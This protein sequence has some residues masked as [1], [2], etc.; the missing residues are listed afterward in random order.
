MPSPR[1][2]TITT[3]LLAGLLGLA[4]C[5]SG[6]SNETASSDSGAAPATSAATSPAT[7]TSSMPPSTSMSPST[8]GTS[9]AST[10]STASAGKVD[11]NNASE[12]EIAAALKQAGVPAPERMA[13][14]IEEYRP[15]TADDIR[16]KLTEELGKYGVDSATVDK[17][18][19]ALSV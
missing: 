5:S 16:P 1:V 13:K 10:A 15:Y 18:V 3:L 6:T 2:T 14:E 11:A 7:A 4:A 19:S 17:I 8:D 12:E 9:T